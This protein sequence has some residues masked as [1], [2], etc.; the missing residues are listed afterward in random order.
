MTKTL[1]PHTIGLACERPGIGVF[2]TT[3]SDFAAF[4]LAGILP[5]PAATPEACTPRN[6]GQ[7][8]CAA[9]AFAKI[10][11]QREV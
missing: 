2:Q 10:K 7:L 11:R 1:S 3:F 9:A 4:Q 5:A 8:S 6:C